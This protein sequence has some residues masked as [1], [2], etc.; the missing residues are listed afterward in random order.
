MSLVNRDPGRA[1]TGLPPR[2]RLRLYSPR[3]CDKYATMRMLTNGNEDNI[4]FSGMDERLDEIETRFIWVVQHQLS[5]LYTGLI[6]K[7]YN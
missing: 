6:T 7:A 4:D 5:V 3:A 2:T 1:T